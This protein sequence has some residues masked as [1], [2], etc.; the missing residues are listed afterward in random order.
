MKKTLKKL[1]NYYLNQFKKKPEFYF[2]KIESNLVIHAFNFSVDKKINKIG[3]LLNKKSKKNLELKLKKLTI[4]I[5]KI[6]IMI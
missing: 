3:K 6:F 2:D 4:A 5:I 1:V